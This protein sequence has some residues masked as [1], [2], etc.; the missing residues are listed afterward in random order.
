MVAWTANTFI[1]SLNV[2][3]IFRFSLYLAAFFWL[4]SFCRLSH[5]LIFSKGDLPSKLLL[6]KMNVFPSFIFL[7]IGG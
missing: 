2:Q 6:I 7:V 3:L 1:K 4:S 5:K